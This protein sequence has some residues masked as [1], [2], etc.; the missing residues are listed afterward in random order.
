MTESEMN[1]IV[2]R[3]LHQVYADKR[4][5]YVRNGG[6]RDGCG[7]LKHGVKAEDVY[8]E[9][10]TLRCPKALK[11]ELNKIIKIW[12]DKR[13]KEYYESLEAAN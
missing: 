7:R 8:G 5:N 1:T 9:M 6:K 2:E 3:V 11:P 13:L 10:S 12:K 4:K